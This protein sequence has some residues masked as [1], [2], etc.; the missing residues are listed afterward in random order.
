MYCLSAALL[1][2][3]L[4]VAVPARTAPVAYTFSV[5]PQYTAVDL[6]RRWTPLLMRLEKDTGIPLQLRLNKSIPA[7]ESEVLA[8]IPDF[9]YLNPYQAVM[10]RRGQ[11][12]S[13]ILRGSRTANGVLVV[14]RGGPV[15]ALRNLNG[16]TVA[17]P[18]PNAFGASLYMR[19]L[20]AGRAGLKIRPDYVGSHQNVYRHVLLGEAVA[21]GGGSETLAREP[22]DVRKRLRVLYTTPA[23]PAHAIVAHPR[24]P[25]E[26][27]ARIGQAII[28]LRADPEG[29][30]LLAGAGLETPVRAAYE[31]DYAPL[32][33]LGLGRYA[34]PPTK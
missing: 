11:G 29:R 33:R 14:R 3:G 7:F 19:A 25:Q 34:V 17:F 6:G 16:K 18:A 15:A 5:E 1:A 30:W 24:V 32:E 27:R 26:I 12:Y 10:A 23:I 21:G 28:E 22:E 20:L 9:A 8:G 2:I 31:R 4:L 13:P